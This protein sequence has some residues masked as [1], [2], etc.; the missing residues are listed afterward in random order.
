MVDAKDNAA[1][2]FYRHHDFIALPNS[3]RTLFLPLATVQ[4]VPSA[5]LSTYGRESDTHAGPW[6]TRTSC[7][8]DVLT[9]RYLNDPCFTPGFGRSEV[10]L[11]FEVEERALK[12]PRCTRHLAEGRP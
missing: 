10:S 8:P 12:A 5:P 7:D 1:A 11:K 3:S 6:S 4:P 9:P 2:S